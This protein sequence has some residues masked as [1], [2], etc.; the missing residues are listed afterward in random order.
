MSLKRFSLAFCLVLVLTGIYVDPA[1]AAIIFQNGFEEGD[2]SAWTGTSG[3]PTVTSAN[4][5]HG[6]CEMTINAG[7]YCYETIVAANIRYIRAY[8]WFIALPTSNVYR[9]SVC[10]F[11]N[12]DFMG[13]PY[14][15]TAYKDPADSLV[16]FAIRNEYSNTWAISTL[17]PSIGQWYYVEIKFSKGATGELWVDGVS[18]AT[19]TCFNLQ[20]D[21]AIAGSPA[22]NQGSAYIDCVVVADAYIGPEAGGPTN[23]PRSAT[24]GITVGVDAD[25]W[26]QG[27][28]GGTQAIG[29][30]PDGERIYGAIRSPTQSITLSSQ[31]N[32][33]L[34][35]TRAATQ[36]LNLLADAVGT[37]LTHTFTRG[38]TL[39]IHFTSNAMT[40]ILMLLIH[41]VDMMN[42]ALTGSTVSV[43]G[44]AGTLVGSGNVNTTGYYVLHGIVAGN[45]TV[46]AM[47]PDYQLGVANQVVTATTTITLTLR[48]I[49]EGIMF[50]LELLIFVALASA[51]TYIGYTTPV[52]GQKM[53]GYFT[54]MLFWLASMYQWIISNPG[55]WGLILAFLAPFMVS[56][57]YGMQSLG[58]YVDRINSKA[59]P[60]E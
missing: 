59:D 56:W 7:E 48:S 39:A 21:A 30:T 49:E 12:S 51:C 9:I 60:F 43:W 11:A 19:L 18:E 28:R 37:A 24:Q 32:R 15:A 10:G 14:Y 13:Y 5:H 47:E 22:S 2:F 36:A 4:P 44:P 26:F 25:R 52:L 53:V 6:S 31:A 46:T 35:M 40:D 8:V 20:V 29:F 54:A 23:Y 33:T 16:K 50:N 55:S 42:H 3:T 45:Y 17:Q 34:T 41:V 1:Y 58:A 38:A 27:Y 57:A